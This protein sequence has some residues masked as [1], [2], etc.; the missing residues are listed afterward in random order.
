MIKLLDGKMCDASCARSCLS[1]DLQVLWVVSAHPS[2][3]FS[4]GV[5][6][7]TS[8]VSLLVRALPCPRYA[9]KTD[10]LAIYNDAMK[11]IR[12]LK[13]DDFRIGIAPYGKTFFPADVSVKCLRAFVLDFFQNSTRK[14][15]SIRR[16]PYY[17]IS[18]IFDDDGPVGGALDMNLVKKLMLANNEFCLMF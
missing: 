12:P 11:A 4:R 17:H 6:P 3:W 5:H 18:S 2:G 14:D 13:L 16:L 8:R 15:D 9:A 1:P 7:S 10:R